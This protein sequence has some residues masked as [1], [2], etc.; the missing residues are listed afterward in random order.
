[1]NKK[2]LSVVLFGALLATSTGTF[3]SCKDYDDD[4]KGLQEQINKGGETVGALQEQLTKQLATL[5]DAVKA[6][7]TAADAAKADAAKAQQAADAAKAVGDNAAE[8]AAKAKTLAEEAK[9]AAADAKAEALAK[10][11][12]EVKLMKTYVDSAVASIREEL[13]G[14]AD[15][16]E[17]DAAVKELEE[18]IELVMSSLSGRI[19]GI[20]ASLNELKSQLGEA[21]GKIEQ[22]IKD[23]QGLIAGL[24]AVN[25]DLATQKEALKNLEAALTEKIEKGDAALKEELEAV[26]AE[27][28]LV[29][30]KIAAAIQESEAKWKQE[31]ENLKDQS[32][33]DLTG[34]KAALELMIQNLNDQM[35]EQKGFLLGE[36]AKQIQLSEA[37]SQEE[38]DRI[39]GRI[40]AIIEGLKNG[41]IAT[42]GDI[43][44]LQGQIN[45]INSRIT[46]VT[47]QLEDRMDDIKD[48]IFTTLRE[49][50]TDI[51]EAIR[52]KITNEVASLHTLIA[53]RLSSMTFVSDAISAGVGDAI[54][55]TSL[56]YDAMPDNENAAI[57]N[58][59]KFSTAALANARYAFNP[60]SFKLSNAT[61]S[62]FDNSAEVLP[63]AIGGMKTRAAQSALVE[64][65]GEP[66]KKDGFVNFQLLRIN[67]HS[68]APE[69]GKVNR[70]FL[71]AEMKG[72]ALTK[73]ETN[74]V[75]TSATPAVV[76]DN[77]LDNEDV[78]IADRETL[79]ADGDEAHYATTIDACAQLPTEYITYEM[80]YDK[81][82]NLKEL[83]ATCYGNGDHSEFPIED[84]KLSYKFSVA[85]TAY[86]IATGETVTDQQDWF[87]CNDAKEGLFQAKNFNRELIGRTPI[88]KVELVDNAGRVV[89]RAFVKL[90]IV[91]DKYEDL[92]V[93]TTETL[94]YG[95]AN[96]DAK[97]EISEQFIR[98]NVYR[99]ITNGKETSMSHE[100]F[101]NLYDASTATVA[102]TKNGKAF[103]MNSK[104]EIVD[105][106]TSVGVA[107][108]KVTW[109]FKHRELGKISTS[110]ST[111]VASITVNNKLASSEFPAKVTFTITVDVNLPSW[112]WAGTENAKFW[113]NNMY[114][115][116]VSIPPLNIDEE[117]ADDCVFRT[118]L[119]QA[120]VAGSY[121][122]TGLPE[123]VENYYE[124]IATV[125]D[126]KTSNKGEAGFITGVVVD[127]T[128]IT[129][130]K[131]NAAV[132]K[133]LNSKLGLQALVAHKY[134]L[135]S[136]DIFTVNTF[137]V[138][139]I[140]PVNLNMP[141]SLKL[142][143]A[144]D[145]SGQSVDFQW[146]GLLTDW[147]GYSI[148]NKVWESVIDI[149]SFWM[150]TCAPEA[151]VIPGYQRVDVPAEITPEYGTVE[152]TTNGATTVYKAT[153]TYRY[154]RLFSKD[155]IKEFTTEE[156]Y[157]T[158]E[159]AAKMLEYQ[160]KAYNAGLGYN[161][162]GLVEINYVTESIPSGTLVKYEYVK[163]IKYTPA[164]Y[165]DVPARIEMVKHTDDDH[166]EMPS[167][168]GSSYGE[169]SGCW[170][171]AKLETDNSHWAAGKYWEFY[172]QFGDVEL[173]IK[174]VY[175][176]ID[177]NGNKLPN[178]GIT[179]TQVG[180]T[181]QYINAGAKVTSPYIIYIPASI[182]YGWGTA[183]ATLTVTVNP[184]N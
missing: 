63:P 151:K 60:A 6:A 65:V 13:G 37:S 5:Q 89:R 132:E 100:E 178:E 69:I 106:A 56:I 164:V 176:D 107:T 70:I 64:I 85:K 66:V 179:L 43:S 24:A 25:E 33:R 50:M 112:S 34:V 167:Y 120:Y 118:S 169:T 36:I 138:N 131:N 35:G 77:L 3:T 160:A 129:L 117:N 92:Q 7:Q 130:T 109:N 31:L 68:T 2:Y 55:F 155:I 113:E 12:A 147:R 26:K 9:A 140:R 110:G 116:Y 108:K 30:G 126:G 146:N 143:D 125:N 136:G 166:S 156:S 137:T 171:W 172:G 28:A 161:Y 22:N 52:T 44:F 149:E 61:Y 127:D 10:I 175:T 53:A 39:E 134:K 141:P 121:K 8:E 153:A 97:F 150:A 48:N 145:G 27:I 182:R 20:D 124:V 11:E 177:Y 1:M 67:A 86:K 40:D 128:D 42:G 148:V 115:A 95:C 180:N 4:I 47:G 99:V 59:F 102:I 162:A 184:V 46:T 16:A 72:E 62:Y 19:D 73:D 114:L 82:F 174:D 157:L 123:C 88:V 32:N 15:K 101:W 83:V 90:I 135:E 163:G 111:F 158:E 170:T 14:K 38:R 54:K 98:D 142:T 168:D 18:S 45:D 49:E 103:T 79:T 80:A 17:L 87:D 104:P 74:A 76:F 96:D 29:D 152:F 133:A 165:E 154:T 93:G 71:Q 122:V 21:N 57:P 41:D 183:H 119:T 84:Y 173:S 51:D 181:L 94:T 159:Q 81:V 78:R 91:A 58:K 23:I 105:G 139:F 75:I 144:Q